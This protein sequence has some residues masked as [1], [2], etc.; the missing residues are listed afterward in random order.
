MAVNDAAE[1]TWLDSTW[2]SYWIGLTDQAEEGTWL[3][4]K[5]SS[6]LKFSSFCLLKKIVA[7]QV[8]PNIFRGTTVFFES[9]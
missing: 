3:C 6:F 5:V 2:G 7:S 1:Q 9:T 8:P 4:A